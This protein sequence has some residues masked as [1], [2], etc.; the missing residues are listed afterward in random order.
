MPRLA[1]RLNGDGL[2]AK[3]CRLDGSTTQH[4]KYGQWT[5]PISQRNKQPKKKEAKA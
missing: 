1:G 3:A 2:M 5:N 4:Q